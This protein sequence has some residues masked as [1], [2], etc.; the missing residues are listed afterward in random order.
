MCQSLCEV[1][2][3]LGV[4]LVVSTATGLA[5]MEHVKSVDRCFGSQEG[6]L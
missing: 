3:A 2:V 1:S 4:W 6:M 5:D